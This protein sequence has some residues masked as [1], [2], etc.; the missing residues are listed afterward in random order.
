MLIDAD[1]T[2]THVEHRRARFDVDEVVADLHQ[3]R[4]PNAAF[5]EAILRSTHAF[6]R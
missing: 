6:A 3:R 5:V 4:H 2:R 1:A